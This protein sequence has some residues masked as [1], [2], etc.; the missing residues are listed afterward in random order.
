MKISRRKFIATGLATTSLAMIGD[1][2]WLEPTWL[3]VRKLRIGDKPS[4]RFVY[5]TDL[6]HKGDRAYAETVVKTINSLSPEFVCF[7]GDIMEDVRFL[8]EA[9]EILSGIK[10]PMFGVPGNHDFWSH[11]PFDV[12]GK[13]FEATG[14]RWLMNE[15][16]PVADGRVHVI[17]A[18]CQ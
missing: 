3:K 17:G 9:L 8:P 10:S 4:H 13:C 2:K 14:G 6:H 15:S 11:A 18:N 16:R 7:G 1:A 12:I 5:F